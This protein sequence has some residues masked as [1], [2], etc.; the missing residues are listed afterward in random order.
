MSQEFHATYEQGIL[1][2]DQ[3]LALP[4]QTRVLGVVKEESLEAG[5]NLPLFETLTDDEFER[6]LDSLSWEVMPLPPDFSRAD[7]Y[8]DHD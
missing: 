8:S 1:R 5:A 2:L 3:P 7:I 4:E 6:E